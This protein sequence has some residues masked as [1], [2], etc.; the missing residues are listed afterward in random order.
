MHADCSSAFR[1]LSFF[2]LFYY[3]RFSAVFPHIMKIFGNVGIVF[4]FVP[5]V[6]PVKILAGE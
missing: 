5:V 1:A 2:L 6:K 4:L 3:K